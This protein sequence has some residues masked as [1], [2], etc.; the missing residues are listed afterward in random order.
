MYE[1]ERNNNLENEQQWKVRNAWE[2]ME[3]C[4]RRKQMHEDAEVLMNEDKKEII[5][6]GNNSSSLYKRWNKKWHNVGP[7]WLFGG[8]KAVPPN[9]ALGHSCLLV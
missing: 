7:R 3:G 1:E 2:Q 5:F 6:Q 9:Q 4:R 8:A